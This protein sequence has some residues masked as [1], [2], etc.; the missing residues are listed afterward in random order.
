MKETYADEGWRTNYWHRSH[1]LAQIKNNQN[2]DWF[3]RLLRIIQKSSPGEKEYKSDAAVNKLSTLDRENQKIIWNTLQDVMIVIVEPKSYIKELGVEITEDYSYVVRLKG[4]GFTISRNDRGIYNAYDDLLKNTISDLVLVHSPIFSVGSSMSQLAI[5]PRREDFF[6]PENVLSMINQKDSKKKV[7]GAIKV[8]SRLFTAF[9]EVID[10]DTRKRIVAE[11]IEYEPIW[12]A[13]PFHSLLLK[14]ALSSDRYFDE[15]DTQSI[16]IIKRCVQEVESSLQ[17]LYDEDSLP[18][19][20]IAEV[21]SEQSP[22]IQ[23]ADWATGIARD[24]YEKGGIDG[25]KKK[26]KYIIYNGELMF[27]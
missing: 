15:G 9:F 21:D 26:F 5:L 16:E 25:V 6:S 3:Y 4:E 19:P 18:H 13:S 1:I 14:E 20:M 12:A 22:Y 8:A 2:L 7:I 11:M 10:P 17:Y 23:A 24:I 27:N